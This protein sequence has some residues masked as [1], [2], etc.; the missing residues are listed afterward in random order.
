MNDGGQI[1]EEQSLEIQGSVTVCSVEVE[2]EIHEENAFN[3]GNFYCETCRKLYVDECDVIPLG[4]HFG[5]FDGEVTSQEKALESAYSWVICRGGD[6]YNY[7][8][9]ERDAHSNWMRYV[10]R[11]QSEKERNL[12]AFQQSGRVLFRRCRPIH[13]GQE[14]RVWYAEDY[15][16][17]LSATWDKIWDRKCSPIGRSDDEEVQALSCPYCQYSFPAAVYL[18]RHVRR[19]HPEEYTHLSSS[20]FR[21]C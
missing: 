15:A 10:V 14:L 9:A 20:G 21:A 13:P 19:S 3:D 17:N 5:P 6:L 4:M 8:D 12:V 11:S 2:T 18:H 7:T 1:G 16:Q